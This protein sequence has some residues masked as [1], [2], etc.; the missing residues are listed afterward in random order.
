KA[1]GSGGVA[2]HQTCRPSV[3][4]VPLSPR[5]GGWFVAGGAECVSLELSSGKHRLAVS[6]AMPS[7]TPAPLPQPVSDPL[8][9]VVVTAYNY[10]DFIADCLRSVQAQTY[11]K[12]ECIVIDD[13]SSDNTPAVVGALLHEWQDSRFRALRLSKNVGQLGAHVEGLRESKGEIVIFVDADDLLFPR[14]I[15]RHLFVHHNIETAVA[16]TSSNQW[17]ISRDG[18]VLSKSHTDLV[19]RV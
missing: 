1:P 13:C 15:E 10:G 4:P 6:H 7:T 11:E 9:S 16:F 17:T 8:I 12:F 2:G 5:Q 14:F 19:S 3:R 18:Q